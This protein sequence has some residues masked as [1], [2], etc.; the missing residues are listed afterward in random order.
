MHCRR[1]STSPSTEHINGILFSTGEHCTHVSPMSRPLRRRPL[2][3][4][5]TN[6]THPSGTI[7]RR[8]GRKQIFRFMKDKEHQL[9]V[10]CIRWFRLQYRGRLIYAVPNGGKRN[11]ITATKLKTEGVVRGVPDLCIPIANRFYHGMYIEMKIKPNTPRIEQKDIM[12][13][14]HTNGY[15]CSVC[16]SIEEFM[17]VVNEYMSNI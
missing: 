17:S 3:S 14:L 11:V 15:K 8:A 5:K 6:Q 4:Q 1:S 2:F 12:F 13:K 16:Y 7:F 10:S 9:Q